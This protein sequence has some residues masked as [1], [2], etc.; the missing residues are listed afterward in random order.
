MFTPNV[1]RAHDAATSSRAPEAAMSDVE[2]RRAVAR[3]MITIGRATDP[4]SALLEHEA[5]IRAAAHRLGPESSISRL[6]AALAQARPQ[7]TAVDPEHGLPDAAAAAF[8]AMLEGELGIAA[9]SVRIVEAIGSDAEGE[10]AT[11][12]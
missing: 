9:D 2:L 7:A 4:T 1:D 10:K 12:G 11:R 5:V 3:A 8:F 6:L